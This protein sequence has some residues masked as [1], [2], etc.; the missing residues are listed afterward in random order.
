VP[1]KLGH[2]FNGWAASFGGTYQGGSS[3]TMPDANVT[4]TAQWTAN[5]FTVSYAAG[6]AN[7]S[8][9]PGGASVLADTQYTVSA[10]V[11][12]K[13]GY[14]FDGWT[15][16][17]GGTYHG[18]SNF[19]MPFANVTLTAQWTANDYTVTYAAGGD[20][21]SGLPGSATVKTDAG[22]TV[23]PAVP[24]RLGH[25]FDGWAASIGGTYHGGGSFVM[26]AENVVLTAQWTAHYFTVSYAAGA[27]G[28]SGL[29]GSATV[30]AETTYAV[31]SAVPAKLGYTFSGW[32]ASFG[33]TYSGGNT[34][35]MPFANVTL[36]AQWTP[37]NY[38]VTYAAGSGG[39]SGLPGGATVR[40]DARY[41]VSSAVPAR[42]NYTFDGWTASFGGTYSGGGAFTMPA[43]NVVL[44]ARWTPDDAYTV[45]YLGNGNTGGT[46][47]ADTGGNAPSGSNAYRSGSTVSV[48][49][50]TGALVQAGYKFTGWNT[51]AGGSGTN[52]TAGNTFVITANTTLYAQW[53]TDTEV[54]PGAAEPE[55][56]AP[57]DA[58][59]LFGGSNPT[60]SLFGNDVPLFGSTAAGS[61]AFINLFLMVIGLVGALLL[62]LAAAH[63][64]RRDREVWSDETEEKQQKRGRFLLMSAVLAVAGLALFFLTE[65]MRTPVVLLDQWTILQAIFAVCTLIVGKQAAKGKIDEE[66]DRKE[67]L[68]TE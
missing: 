65:D 55:A 23:S 12:T 22:Y 10:A 57:D 38:T 42:V 40:V 51:A 32:T 35:T 54:I 46:A 16:S 2:T 53:T 3:F 8:G 5:Y 31:A 26:P 28:V 44:T 66:D 21:V 13:L 6:A 59:G 33:G 50:N 34:F 48:L 36:T 45:T 7:V 18:G 61:W 62:I 58:Q 19:K 68:V 52:Y 47:P 56:P 27:A 41:T 60:F 37:N 4:L 67:R 20:G 1:A 63:R 24:T 30:L 43:A 17:A 39:V 11:P 15:S 64:K 49:G 14:T 9:L 29:P 25:T